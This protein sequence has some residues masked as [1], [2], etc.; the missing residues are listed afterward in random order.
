MD[1][2]RSNPTSRGDPRRTLPGACW[3]CSLGLCRPDPAANTPHLAAYPVVVAKAERSL[4]AVPTEVV[5]T[6]HPAHEA[7]IAAL[8]SGT[9][10]EVRVGVGSFVQLGRSAGEAHGP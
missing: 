2:E 8:V 6:V 10:T 7:A 9:V 3:P 4:Q 5:G 1:T